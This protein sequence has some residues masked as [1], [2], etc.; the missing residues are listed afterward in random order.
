MGRNWQLWLQNE[1]LTAMSKNSLYSHY[2]GQFPCFETYDV[3]EVSPTPISVTGCHYP[4][5][6]V[7]FF[8][9]NGS[10]WE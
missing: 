4:Q 5:D 7:L 8:I 10:K 9:V 1:Y 2:F 6:F 3:L